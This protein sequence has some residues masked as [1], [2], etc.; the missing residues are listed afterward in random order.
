MVSRETEGSESVQVS[1]ETGAQRSGSK[2][3]DPQVVTSTLDEETVAAIIVGYRDGVTILDLVGEHDMTTAEKLAFNI[4]EQIARS[5]GIV[6]SL[7]ETDFIDCSIL[8]VLFRGDRQMLRRGR[9]LVI[10]TSYC[11]PIRRILEL[12]GVSDQ[13]LCCDSLEEAIAFASQ[14]CA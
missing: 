8:R 11:D 13:L 4:D 7:T 5:R 12:T 3:S 6:I 10:H 1:P 9:R 14:S 2:R